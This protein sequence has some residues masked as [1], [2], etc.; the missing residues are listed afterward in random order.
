MT[1][2]GSKSLGDQGRNAIE[3]I[4]H[5]YG[6]DMYLETAPR[7]SGVPTSWGGVNLQVGSTG[8]DVRIIQQQ[9]NAVSQNFPAIPR[10]RVDGVFGEQTRDA[11]ATFQEVFNLPPNGIVDYP[12]WYRISDI[13]VAVTRIAELM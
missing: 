7:V 8:E 12:T 5:F 9:L 11:V 3:I 1:Q 2:W 13:Y 4:R 10:V 6:Q